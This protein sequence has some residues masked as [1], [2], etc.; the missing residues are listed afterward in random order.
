MDSTTTERRGA[1]EPPRVTVGPYP[2]AL[3]RVQD[4]VSLFAVSVSLNHV[5]P[6]RCAA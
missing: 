3:C 5:V 2:F 4:S 1:I 6:T